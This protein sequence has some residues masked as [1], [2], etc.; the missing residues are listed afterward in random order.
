MA[1]PRK[2]KKVLEITGSIRRNP[3]RY[4]GRGEAPGSAELGPLGNP[5]THL[6]IDVQACWIELA[7]LDA[8]NCKV[9]TRSDR[10]SVEIAAQLMTEFRRDPAAFPAA[11]MSI[12]QRLLKSFGMLGVQSREGW[13]PEEP[14]DDGPLAEFFR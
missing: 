14:E 13:I 7:E 5:P 8:K 1:P 9:L 10:L 3:G 6:D 2:S 11:R 4:A 12:L